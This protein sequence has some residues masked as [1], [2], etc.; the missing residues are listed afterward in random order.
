M[1]NPIILISLILFTFTVSAQ[2]KTKEKTY[3][4]LTACGQC[5]M[6]MNY[7]KGCDLAVQIAG[8]KY[9]VDG[10]DISDHGN[11]HTPDGLCKTVRKAEATGQIK[12]DRFQVSSFTLLPEKKKKK[13]K[14]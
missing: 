12:G 4:V 1:K 7:I 14:K 6:D 8:K 10:T 9:W 3:K 11:E 5:Q 13:A 2:K